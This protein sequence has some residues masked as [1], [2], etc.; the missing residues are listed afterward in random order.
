MKDDDFSVFEVSNG[1]L[2]Q[3]CVGIGGW[4]DFRRVGLKTQRLKLKD[5][6]LP[7]FIFWKQSDCVM[8]C[9]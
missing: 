4:Y 8:F 3:N 5:I 1:F 7:E 9:F 6:V 2:G